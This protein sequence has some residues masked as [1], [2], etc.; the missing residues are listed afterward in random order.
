MSRFQCPGTQV[1]L[2]FDSDDF[3]H[4][5]GVVRKVE[6]GTGTD[7]DDSSVEAGKEPLAMGEPPVA[8]CVSD[9]RS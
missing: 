3:A 7:L 1:R 9:S 2:G 6:A 8:S 5:L 4:A